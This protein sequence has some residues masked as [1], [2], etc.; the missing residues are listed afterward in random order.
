[1]APRWAW[2]S[3]TV[4]PN[5]SGSSSFAVD[6]PRPAGPLNWCSPTPMRA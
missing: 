4:R 2:P 5:R 3:A 6:P 1:M